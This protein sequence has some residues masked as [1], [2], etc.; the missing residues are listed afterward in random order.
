MVWW[1]GVGVVAFTMKPLPS[2]LLVK[3][4]HM[5]PNCFGWNW[6]G[7]YHGKKKLYVVEVR[8]K[9]PKSPQDY[10]FINFRTRQ[11]SCQPWDF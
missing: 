7:V 5:F 8:S 6:T 2:R 11:H 3:H 9:F 4:A 1:L 10:S